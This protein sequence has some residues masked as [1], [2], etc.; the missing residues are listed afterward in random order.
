MSIAAQETDPSPLYLRI[1]D[2][3]AQ[4]IASGVL[5]AGDRVPS[6]RRLSRDQ[7]VS[8]STALQAYLALESRGLIE[9][10]PRSGFF[11]SATPVRVLPTP[12][13]VHEKPPQPTAV[14]IDTVLSDI[15]T[16]ANDPSN[17]PF[18]IG[19][20]A[21]E[22]FPTRKL[23]QIVRQV[24]RETPNHSAHYEFGSEALRRQI[25]RRSISLRCNFAP[26]D[27]TITS[28]GLEAINLSL[29]AIAKPG[30]VIAVETP[31]FFG[32]LGCIASLKMKVIEIPTDPHDGMD[33]GALEDAIRRHHVKA[34]V[35]TAN[36]HNPLG[37]VLNDRQKRALVDLTSRHEIPV[38]EDDVYGDLVF[39]GARPASLK[40]FDRKDLVLLCSSFSKS[41]SPGYRVGWVVAGRYR[42]EVERLK[43]LTNVATPSLSQLVIAEFLQSGGYD[44]YLRRLQPELARQ[45]SI[46]RHAVAAHFPDG[47]R[48]TQPAGGHMLWIE[49]PR[50][51][52][53]MDLYQA[54]LERHISILPGPIFSASGL[55]KHH[56]RINTGSGW[57]LRHERALATLGR[58]C[59][60]RNA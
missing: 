60:R 29:R 34:C 38:I 49:L 44:R 55:Y 32:I 40:T 6:L 58:L 43:L 20:A 42:A 53:A 51:I 16:R 33:L 41:L 4:Q 57:T 56:L 18:G 1:S 9:S 17:V 3:L 14:G 30:E 8:V 22:L 27:V 35:V 7:R 59:A 25:A 50:S 24:V 47:T 10:R 23:N 28:G 15:L 5:R 11:V 39:D 26:D 13:F 36:C 45:T 52:D 54:A 31:T 46:V 19:S 2:R 48:V 12:Q 37:F 21:P